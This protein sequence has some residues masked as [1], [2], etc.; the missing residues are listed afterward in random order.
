MKTNELRIGNYVNVLH[1]KNDCPDP[2]KFNIACKIKAVFENAIVLMS[3]EY[4]ELEY[5]SAIP[6][7]EEIL[8]KCG[9]SESEMFF[10]RMRGFSIRFKDKVWLG[11]TKSNN[12]WLTCSPHY[13]TCLMYL[14]QLQNLYFALT[15]EELIINL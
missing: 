9:F 8:L 5:I 13:D 1:H 12:G 11:L 2:V 3:N 6:L 4:V 7:T 14:H 10:I 15:N